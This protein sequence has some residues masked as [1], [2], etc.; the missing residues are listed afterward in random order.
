MGLDIWGDYGGGD[1][2]FTLSSDDPIGIFNVGYQQPL[3]TSSTNLFAGDY[4]MA[5]ATSASS[6]SGDAGGSWLGDLQTLTNQASSIIRTGVA[7]AADVQT[8]FGG[9]D[10]SQAVAL[11]RSQLAQAAAAGQGVTTARS[12]WDPSA[13]LKTPAGQ[14]MLLIGVV[15]IGLYLMRRAK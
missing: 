4:P 8:T 15:V 7:T 9:A 1:S 14:K 6:S 2:S 3:D 10:S 11:N 13:Y 5:I 12:T